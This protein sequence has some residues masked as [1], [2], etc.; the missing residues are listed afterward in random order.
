MKDLTTKY[1]GL[2][3]KNPIVVGSCSLTSS[4]SEIKKL[5][6]NG[7]AAV[8]LKSI[9]EE[10]IL[11]DA[12]SQLREAKE[13]SFIYD[14]Y[15]ETL[16]Y[17]DFHVK[18]ER[19]N[20]Y[21]QLIKQAKKEVLI[22]IIASINCVSSAEWTSF[23]K[24]IEEAGADALELNV[25]LNPT[26]LEIRDFEQTI[27]IIIQK[28]L[29]QV[30]IPVS[31]KINNSFT[32]M[33]RTILDLSQT[34]IAGLVLFNR[35]YAPDIDINTFEAVQGRSFSSPE[36]YTETMRWI[37]L[38]SDKVKCSLAASSGIHSSEAI[39]KQI[40]AGADA[41]QVV[42]ALYEHSTE[43]INVLLDGI[44]KWMEEKGFSSLEQFKG[45]ASSKNLSNP[46]VFER[47]QFMKHFSGI[48]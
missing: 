18:E 24:R 28:V 5:E 1:L 43:H 27:K 7:A 2:N 38:L 3:L 20:D 23:A 35:A 11:M 30:K 32:H 39:I 33:A 48:N 34:G 12:E 41:V 9:F 37:A 13:N 22:P 29:A 25:S 42:S 21:I 10:E 17:I 14:K 40:L 6:K 16:D 4:L 36:S 19:L 26:D 47:I 31:V 15:S 46:A 44:E 8:V 45:K